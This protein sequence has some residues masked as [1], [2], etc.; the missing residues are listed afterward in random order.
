[1]ISAQNPLLRT[2]RNPEQAYNKHLQ[3]YTSFQVLLFSWLM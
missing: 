2:E 1:M 3:P